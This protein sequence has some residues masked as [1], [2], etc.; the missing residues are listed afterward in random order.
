MRG[1]GEA[2]ELRLKLHSDRFQSPLRHIN[3]LWL[4]PLSSYG[5][6]GQPCVELHY[7]S[8]NGVSSRRSS[9]SDV[10]VFVG[11]CLSGVQCTACV[12]YAKRTSKGLRRKPRSR[13]RFLAGYKIEK[14]AL[15]GCLG[16]EK[17]GRFLR[18]KAMGRYR[19]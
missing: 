18:R 17:E 10:L 3:P 12:A 4:D 19:L 2:P 14:N 5:F 1:I 9:V 16:I 11:E 13:I 6:S 8:W 7:S 15:D